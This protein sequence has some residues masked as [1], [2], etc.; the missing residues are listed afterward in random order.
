MLQCVHLKYS[1]TP[2]PSI[3]CFYAVYSAFFC[4][5]ED[6]NMRS[7]RLYYRLAVGGSSHVTATRRAGMRCAWRGGC[8]CVALWWRADTCKQRCHATTLHPSR[9]AFPPFP[10]FLYFLSCSAMWSG[11]YGVGVRMRVC[12]ECRGCGRKAFCRFWMRDDTA[13]CSGAVRGTPPPSHACLN[14]SSLSVLG[15]AFSCHS[16]CCPFFTFL[17]RAAVAL[18]GHELRRQKRLSRFC[19]RH[20]ATTVT[21]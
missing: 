13:C 6:L 7:R 14:I 20:S 8:A 15:D 11:L 9:R 5:K 21:W 1:S 12:W 3:A 16:F 18:S 19:R 4:S 2:L 17:E 10:T